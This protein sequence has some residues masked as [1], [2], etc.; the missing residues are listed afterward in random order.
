MQDLSISLIQTH[1]AW[2][3]P[4]AN[5][6]HFGAKIA[7]I[8]E[9]T[10]L[11]IL[12]EMF[13]T[14]FTMEAAKNAEEVD[15]KSI[16]WMAE[17]AGEKA[18]VIC[19]SLI[20]HDN[21]HYFNRLIWMRPDGSY[22]KYDKKHLFRMGDEHKHYSA[23]RERLIVEIKGW[24]VIPMICYDLRFPVWSKNE[25]RNGE[26]AFDLMVYVTN[27]PAARS[28]AFTSLLA[29]RAIENMAYVAG[30]NRIGADGR[31]YVFEGRSR[32]V[33]PEGNILLDPGANKEAIS[34]L[35]LKPE[36]LLEV[37][38]RLGVGKDWDKFELL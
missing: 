25:Y 16:R 30:S 3:D 27:W 12:P 1:V 33:G 5:R 38:A 8:A 24:K 2:E 9:P 21:G 10:D 14:G 11:I 17:M 37:R 29:G 26:Y 31:E 32:I 13:T 36:P 35:T 19:G 23:G 22:E 4:V 28:T 15:G 6:D 20:I 34:S 18:C 7:S